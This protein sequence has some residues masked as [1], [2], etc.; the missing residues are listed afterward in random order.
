VCFLRLAENRGILVEISTRLKLQEIYFLL[1][2]R[3]FLVCNLFRN[4]SSTKKKIYRASAK[5]EIQKMMNTNELTRFLKRRHEKPFRQYSPYIAETWNTLSNIGFWIGAMYLH[6]TV[7]S[8]T[9]ANVYIGLVP[10]NTRSWLT[11][12]MVLVGL[13]SGIH[14]AIC[15]RYER[16]SL[17]LDWIPIV[18]SILTF[19]SIDTSC[20]GVFGPTSWV[21]ICICTMAL[22]FLISDH[23]CR[24]LPPPIGHV[25]WHFTAALAM[26]MVYRDYFLF[27]CSRVNP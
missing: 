2:P 27:H 18:M 7:Q 26:T 25:L 1:I 19:L 4:G 16:Y 8:P 11:V 10:A 22:V 13:C 21:T 3:K 9:L 14:H 12:L 15:D 20:C 6:Y 5:E 24:L 17:V 23:A